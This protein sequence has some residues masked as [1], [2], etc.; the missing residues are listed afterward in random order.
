VDKSRAAFPET[1]LH[2][3]QRAGRIWHLTTKVRW[4]SGLSR[5]RG[6]VG[7]G[8]AGSLEKMKEPR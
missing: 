4:R 7:T 8:T 1:R 5:S 2:R 6:Q 3:G